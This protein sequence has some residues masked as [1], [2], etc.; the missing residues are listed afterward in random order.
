MGFQVS[1]NIDAKTLERALRNGV[2]EL[3]RVAAQSM[4][5]VLDAWKAASVNLALKEFSTLRRG[6]SVE[7][8]LDGDALSGT[9]TSVAI[10]DSPKW[11]NFNYAYYWHEVRKD[12]PPKNP[13]T[14]GTINTYLDTAAEQ[15]QDKW[16]SM[17]KRDLEKCISRIGR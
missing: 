9:I 8:G 12:S 2:D 4:G 10:E 13:T 17:I 11:P 3:Q 14:P 7:Q 1:L 5:D 6:I 16:Q 15:N